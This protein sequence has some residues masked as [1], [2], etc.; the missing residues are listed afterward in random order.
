MKQVPLKDTTLSLEQPSTDYEAVT[1]KDTTL[2]L[3]QPD[4]D[5]ETGSLKDTTLSL[6]QPRHRLLNRHPKGH[7]TKPRTAQTQTMKQVP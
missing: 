6:D 2:S 1:V 3:E 7:Y 5:Y 4:T